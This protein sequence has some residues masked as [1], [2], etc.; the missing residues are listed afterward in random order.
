MDNTQE[1]VVGFNQVEGQG[2]PPD[3]EIVTTTTEDSPI[4]IASG[5]GV[6]F[7]RSLQLLDVKKKLNDIMSLRQS[8]KKT[9]GEIISDDDEMEHL[10]DIVRQYTQEEISKFGKEE[11]DAIYVCT[12]TGKPI[13]L[14]NLAPE[15]EY[16]FKKDFLLSKKQSQSII[17][18]MDIEQAKFE[19]EYAESEAELVALIDKFDDMNLILKDKMIEAHESTE[20]PIL[21]EK[22]RLALEAFDNAFTLQCVYDTYSRLGKYNQM[23]DYKSRGEQI[24]KKFLTKIKPLGLRTDL[25]RFQQFEIRFLDSKYHY[26]TDFFLFLVFKHVLHR[27]GPATREW[28]ATFLTQFTINMKKLYDGKMKPEDKEIFLGNINRVLSL[29]DGLYTINKNLQKED[30]QM[31]ENEVVAEVVEQAIEACE[32]GACECTEE[33]VEEAVV[34][35][36]A[37]VVEEEV[38]AAE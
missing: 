8:I 23:F 36:E 2:N 9:E 15:K 37:P 19:K 14:P 5:A 22:Y 25:S 12:K 26:Y 16:E 32:G 17:E 7:Q 4:D 18:F 31:T 20:D 3:M 29:F 6:D 38:P 1:N 34:A 24:Y 11:L 21:K 27:K 13:A 35:E 30:T 33:V 10:D 28:D